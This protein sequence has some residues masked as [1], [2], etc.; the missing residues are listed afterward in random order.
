MLYDLDE[1][2]APHTA[3]TLMQRGYNNIFVLS[4]GLKVAQ[5]CFSHGLIVTDPVTAVSLDPAKILSTQLIQLGYRYK[6]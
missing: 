4:G 2:L 3:S 1:T 5:I 6:K